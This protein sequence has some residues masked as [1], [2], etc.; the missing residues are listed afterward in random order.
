MLQPN[1]GLPGKLPTTGDYKGGASASP[2]KTLRRY[3][4]HLLG[5]LGPQGWWPAKTRLEVILG[6]ILTQN[7]NWRNAA[8]AITQLRERG[9]LSLNRLRAVDEAE[10]QLL[11]RPAGFFTQKARAIRGFLAWLDATH[12]GSLERM[13][14]NPVERL[15]TDLLGLKGLGPE[16]VDAILLYAGGKPFFVADAYTRRILARHHLLP[17]NSGYEQAQTFIQGNLE[18]EAGVYNEFHALLVEVGKRYCGRSATECAA[19]PL[20]VFL[21]R[22]AAIQPTRNVKASRA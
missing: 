20:E 16:T 3:Y 11:I 15:R 10:L 14:E 8:R 1:D 22:M 18:R 21:P 13:F 7:T 6:A 9:L 5:A 19:C 4:E 17:E 2:Q 12:A